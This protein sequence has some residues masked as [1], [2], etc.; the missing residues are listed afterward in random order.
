MDKIVSAEKMR[1]LEK[2]I[3]D[4]G[5]DS[6]AVM[7]KAAMTI[8]EEVKK[9]FGTDT[10]VLVCCGKGNNGGD[11][12][13]VARMLL[14][15]GYKVAICLPLGEPSTADATKNFEIIQKLNVEIVSEKEDFSIFDVI[16]DAIL[17]TGISKDVDLPV[18]DKI[19][20]S[21]AFVIAADI[22]TGISSD[23]GRVLKMA[24]QADLT[25]ALAFKK[26]GH[27]I[28][29]GKEYCGEIV[30]KDIGIPFEGD[31][32]TFE[33][34]AEYI[35]SILPAADVQAHKGDMG[36]ISVIAG[37]KGFTGA[38]T[39]CSESVLKSGGGLVT[40][41]TP[42]NLNEIYEKKLTEAMT[43]PLDCN[44]CLDADL[45]LGKA[46]TL[47]KADAVV[48]GPGLGRDCD[49]GKII[50]FL[51]E[52]EIPVV[53]DADG[54]NKV[55]ANINILN[56]KKGKTV[57]TPHIGE[58]S[59]L[60]GLS[61]DEILADRLEKAREFAIKHGVTLVLKGAGTVIAQPDGV[62]F[63]NH[64]GNSGMA[65]GGSGD[66]LTGILGAFLARGMST[67]NA[68]VAAVYIHGLAGDIA[69]DSLGSESMLPTDVIGFI[70][71]AFLKIKNQD[72]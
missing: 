56:E 11:G 2:R 52:N 60:T 43:L 55:A 67:E 20:N 51:F 39:L 33:V 46:D 63:I 18:I 9:R 47:K 19:N 71:K 6:F 41:F 34:D 40:L 25:V 23:S 54:I 64:T 30:I 3:F 27:S 62:C 50:R 42:E 1:S 48:I 35:N 32:D 59:R 45:V 38:A 15:D 5:V 70:H 24:V 49:A 53:I 37:S 12:L 7:E 26:K 72:R 10:K 58:F 4:L 13:A 8:A 68:A 69:K 28:Y 17:G 65:T 21:P 29:L 22:P 14:L 44:D 66:V 61:S 16:V 57:L 36:R 31:C